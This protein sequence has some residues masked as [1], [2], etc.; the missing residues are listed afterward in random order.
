MTG[1]SELPCAFFRGVSQSI[2]SGGVCSIDDQ[3]LYLHGLSCLCCHMQGSVP[4]VL[5]E[6]KSE[7]KKKKRDSVFV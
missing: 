5:K 3:E 7:R 1:V 6:R 2:K 4:T